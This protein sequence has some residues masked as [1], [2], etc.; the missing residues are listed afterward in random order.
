[1]VV[2]RHLCERFYCYLKHF[3]GRNFT[4]NKVVGQAVL[5]HSVEWHALRYTLEPLIRALR[6]H[7]YVLDW[8]KVAWR[9]FQ[10]K[11]LFLKIFFLWTIFFLGG[12]GKWWCFKTKTPTI[13]FAC[14]TENVQTTLLTCT[15]LFV[16]GW[17]T[18]E[19]WASD[20]NIH[21][22]FFY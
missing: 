5:P 2:G 16:H 21:Y 6:F 3:P 18:W 15:I 22:K 4:A 11:K 13:A 10:G 12:G 19:C 17:W 1:M 14:A 9:D 8:I 7:P 20:N